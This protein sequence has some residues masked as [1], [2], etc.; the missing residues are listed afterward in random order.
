MNGK[1]KIRKKCFIKKTTL[2][3]RDSKKDSFLKKVS[4]FII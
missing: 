2:F 4:D 1:I 3:K